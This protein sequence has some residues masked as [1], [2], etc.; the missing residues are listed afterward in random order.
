M[1]KMTPTEFLKKRNIIKEDKTD[2][3]IKFEDDRVISLI[4][5]LESYH[6]EK[7]KLLKNG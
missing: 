5:L 1:N 7:L 4:E 3:K 6:E 2:L